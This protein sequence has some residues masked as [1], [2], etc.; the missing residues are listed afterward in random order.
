MITDEILLARKLTNVNL[1]FRRLLSDD[2]RLRL[3]EIW[4]KMEITQLHV[5][6]ALAT[7]VLVVGLASV[8]LSL[9]PTSHAHNRPMFEIYWNDVEALIKS[10]MEIRKT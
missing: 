7:L 1:L 10:Y 3:R 8:L 2:M 9:V 4:D 5:R 6:Y